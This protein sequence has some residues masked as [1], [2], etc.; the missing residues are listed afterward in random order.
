MVPLKR[1]PVVF[2]VN[3]MKLDK[4]ANKN[5]HKLRKTFRELLSKKGLKILHLNIRGLLGKK[6]RICHILDAFQ[7]IRIFSVS[8]THLSTDDEAQAQI[9]GFTFIGKSRASAQGGG[10]G[11]YISSS[12]PFHRR[13]DLEQEDIECIWLEILFPKTKGL[14][15]GIIYRP[16][17]SSKHLCPDFNCKFDSMLSTVSSENKECILTGD[18]NYNF[19]ARFYC[20]FYVVGNESLRKATD[21]IFCNGF[22][23][24]QV[25]DW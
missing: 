24:T 16:P 25:I 22:L 18:I 20:K 19:L 1:R 15:I 2:V 11:A 23:I 12:V 6:P 21:V 17:D 4:N 13:L 8:E 7:N 9:D 5:R 10:V 3:T 14:L